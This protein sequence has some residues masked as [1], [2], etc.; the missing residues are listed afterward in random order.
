MPPCMHRDGC[1]PAAV[2]WGAMGRSRRALTT[3]HLA[4]PT[5]S[6]TTAPAIGCPTALPA[7]TLPPRPHRQSPKP[8]CLDPH[9]RP[10]PN[11]SALPLPARISPPHCEPTRISIGR[12]GQSTRQTTH[13]AS[14]TIINDAVKVGARGAHA[15]KLSTTHPRVHGTR[16]TVHG[17]PPRVPL[18]L[19]PPWAPPGSRSPPVSIT[20]ENPT[21]ARQPQSPVEKRYLVVVDVVFALWCY[22]ST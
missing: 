14:A 4:Q 3:L 2:A 16:Y 20:S 22:L 15:D 17:T 9:A 5:P 13:C 7:T 11:R 12:V 21:S 18:V 1:L 10:P 8:P 6:P 19:P